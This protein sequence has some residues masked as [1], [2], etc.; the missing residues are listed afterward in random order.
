METTQPTRKRASNSEADGITRTKRK[1]VSADRKAEQVAEMKSE[2]KQMHGTRWKYNELQYRLWAEVL[3][4]GVYTDTE[5]PPPY[6]MFGK[7]HKAKSA[8]NQDNSK[9]PMPATS[10]TLSP[11]T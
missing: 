9:I 6:P 5:D 3:V 10:L 11:G 7:G 4:S 8:V 2:L 1:R